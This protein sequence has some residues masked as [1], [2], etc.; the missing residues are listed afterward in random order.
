MEDKFEHST[1]KIIETLLSGMDVLIRNRN[2]YAAAMLGSICIE[3]LGRCKNDTA[4]WLDDNNAKDNFNRALKELNGLTIYQE[5]GVSGF[6]KKDIPNDVKDDY[7]ALKNA[8]KSLRKPLEEKKKCEKR[9][10]DSL[11]KHNLSLMELDGFDFYKYF[12]CGFAHTGRPQGNLALTD[13]IP[14]EFCKENTSSENTSS[15]D[16][17]KEGLWVSNEQ[18]LVIIGVDE[19]AKNI[20]KALKQLQDENN[21]H[22]NEHFLT[23]SKISNK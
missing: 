7:E 2:Q 8:K 18:K 23:I 11:K 5:Q 22:I 15:G 16:I 9:V 12:R 14:Q 13:S 17:L 21:V 10:A 4:N 6:C 19:L 20:R 1:G 3:L